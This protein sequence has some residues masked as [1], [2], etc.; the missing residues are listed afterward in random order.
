[1]CVCV[2]VRAGHLQCGDQTEPLPGPPAALLLERAAVGPHPLGEVLQ[3]R[4]GPQG[5]VPFDHLDLVFLCSYVLWVI[6]GSC[7]CD[8]VAYACC[9]SAMAATALALWVQ[10]NVPAVLLSQNIDPW[11][12]SI[13]WWHSMYLRVWT[14]VCKLLRS[15]HNNTFH[16]YYSISRSEP[17]VSSRPPVAS[18]H[19]ESQHCSSQCL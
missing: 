9:I 10:T 18:F 17:I 14:F 7:M 12:H 5:E 15:T 13:P 16:M 4:V 2:C 11:S 8:S 3:R 19:L 1:M 6:V